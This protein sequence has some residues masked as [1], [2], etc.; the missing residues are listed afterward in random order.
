M[1]GNNH[2]GWKTTKEGQHFLCSENGEIQAGFGGRF[3]G[4][5]V[6]SAF[7]QLK[8]SKKENRSVSEKPGENKQKTEIKPKEEVVTKTGMTKTQVKELVLEFEKLQ[9][10]L[11]KK[12]GKKAKIQQMSSS[13]YKKYAELAMKMNSVPMQY[14]DRRN[15]KRFDEK[16][17][18]AMTLDK[19][20]EYI[21][22]GLNMDAIN[23]KTYKHSCRI[24]SMS[25]DKTYYTDEGYLIDHPVVTTCGIFEYRNEDGTTRRELRLPEDVFAEESLKSYKGKPI[26]I[27]HEAGE[28]DKDNVRGEQIGTIMSSGYRDGDSVRCEIIIH[29]TNALKSCG[30]KEL[31]LGYSLDTDDTPGVYRGEPYDCVQKNIEINHLALV[32]EARAGQKA[33]LNIDGKEDDIQIL[34]GGRVIMYK[35]DSKSPGADGQTELSPEEMEAAIA[36]FKAQ[37]AVNQ[38][39]GEGTDGEPA[40]EESEVDA[41]EAAEKNPIDKVRENISRREGEGESMAP[42]D[43]IAEQKADLDLLLSEIDKLLAVRDMNDDS[44][45][46]AAGREEETPSEEEDEDSPKESLEKPN[47]KRVNMDS[48]DRI[49]Q[50]RLDI[51]RMADRLHLDGVEKL[52]VRE[53][54]KR[55]IRVVNPK[56]N[57]DGKSDSYINA[58]YDIA[59]Q[60]F[61]ERVSTD[62]QRR[63][64]IGDKVRQ[65]AREESNSNSARKNM[66]SRMRGERK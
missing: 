39:R 46:G 64:M 47:E 33:R 58:A 16:D 9:D 45:G 48:V 60:T 27:T 19:A 26:I 6:S 10:D 38:A 13:E 17:I 54:R 28:V 43:M 2:D 35:L 25:I 56:V 15:P 20:C 50:E 34:K 44:T 11:K 24:D 57:L 1:G 8:S 41:N 59:K 23:D 61:S 21:M 29:D 51:C 5:N 7:G 40:G 30:L 32:G 55:I 42:K 49:I 22:F 12:Y 65:D 37:Q 3:N 31:S 63:R 4:E 14:R 36:L 52:T 62:D 18:G 66:I 53:G